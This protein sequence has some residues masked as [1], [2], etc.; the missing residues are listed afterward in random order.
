MSSNKTVVSSISILIIL[1]AA[2]SSQSNN[3]VAIAT[4]TSQ[5]Q[6]QLST[7][8]SSVF[9]SVESAKEEVKLVSIVV[10]LEAGNGTGTIT[11]SGDSSRWQSGLPIS[12]VKFR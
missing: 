12:L 6:P 10:S 9:S 7:N 2:C 3:S 4:T 5:T 11:I 1:T 8:E